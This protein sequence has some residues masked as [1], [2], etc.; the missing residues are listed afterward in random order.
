MVVGMN[1]AKK[2]KET[3]RKKNHVKEIL[4][5]GT[6]QIVKVKTSLNTFRVNRPFQFMD[7]ILSKFLHF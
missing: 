6:F 5:R 7:K 1:A 4:V 2:I 3:Q